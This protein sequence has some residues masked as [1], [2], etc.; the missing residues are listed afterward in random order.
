MC[1]PG[2]PARPLKKQKTGTDVL[3]AFFAEHHHP[4]KLGVD[5]Q[6]KKPDEQAHPV[7]YFCGEKGIL[8][9]LRCESD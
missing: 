3:V 7:F 6:Q 2:A 8:S 5:T 1:I 9:P 4:S